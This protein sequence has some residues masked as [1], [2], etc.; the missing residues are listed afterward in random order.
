MARS[1]RRVVIA[2]AI[3]RS[4][5]YAIW[6]RFGTL[7]ATSGKHFGRGIVAGASIWSGFGAALGDVWEALWS[8]RRRGC[9]DL[10]RFWSGL[11]RRVGSALV[12][13]VSRGRRCGHV[14][15]RCGRRV[16]IA[17]AFMSI[18]AGRPV[19]GYGLSK[20]GL[21]VYRASERSAVVAEAS[22]ERR[23]GAASE[24][25]IAAASD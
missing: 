22:R 25:H 19:T 11:E 1:G 4:S 21:F 8:R 20:C 5:R 3:C 18:P 7:R 14:L 9:V 2:V 15:A 16:G 23:F 12:A 10:E 24:R 6:A 13:E 17:L